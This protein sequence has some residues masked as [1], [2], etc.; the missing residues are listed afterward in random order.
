MLAV[1]ASPAFYNRY[2]ILSGA[3]DSYPFFKDAVGAIDETYFHCHPTKDEQ[4]ACCNSKGALI[5][6][7]LTCCSFN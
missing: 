6:K 1:F 5:Q 2:I 3:L 7:C 4:E